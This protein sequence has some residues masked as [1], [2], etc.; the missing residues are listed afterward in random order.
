MENNN[1]FVVEN[2]KA[3]PIST[4]N[5]IY[6][7]TRDGRV[8]MKKS[9]KD[10]KKHV[11]EL[12]RGCRHRSRV[13]LIG[14][15][16]LKRDRDIDNLWKTVCDGLNNIAYDDDKQVHIALIRKHMIKEKKE[17]RLEVEVVDEHDERFKTLSN[18]V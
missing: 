3:C 12:Y 14:D 10:F 2:T 1:K 16:Y 18:I 17:E 5:H 6:G 7:R 8:Y 9:A 4:V 15:A 11:G 13:L